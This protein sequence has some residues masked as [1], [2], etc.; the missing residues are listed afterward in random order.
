MPDSPTAFKNV[1]A[2]HQHLSELF[3]QVRNALRTEGVGREELAALLD[4][5]QVHALDHFSHEEQD[6]LFERIAAHAPRLSEEALD[7]K[8]QHQALAETLERVVESVKLD[9]WNPR[10][11]EETSNRFTEFLLQFDEHEESEN[12]LLQEAYDRDV[13]SK[14]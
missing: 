12:R 9:G 14:D 4:D 10:R 8:Q 1:L 5:L 6:G 11:A 2:D 13:G 3:S 7:L